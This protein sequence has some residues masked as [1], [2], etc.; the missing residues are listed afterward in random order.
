MLDFE[1]VLNKFVREHPPRPNKHVVYHHEFVYVRQDNDQG[2]V[3]AY[4][5]SAS[6]SYKDQGR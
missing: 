2:I 4:F 6:A 3:G 5:T 1:P